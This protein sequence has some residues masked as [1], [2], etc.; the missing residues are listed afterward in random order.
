DAV[1]GSGASRQVT[2][3]PAC[4]K[5]GTA[6]ITVTVRDGVLQASDTFLLTVNPVN[7]PPTISD[8]V[9]QTINQDTSTGPLSF[10]VSD[11]ETP[12]ASLTVSGSSSNPT[13]GPHA[14]IVFGGS[15][16]NRPGTVSAAGGRLG[17]RPIA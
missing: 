3:L 7:D 8:I 10:T 14:N 1:C 12:A 5:S 6:T 2:V 15:G 11:V 13:L 9:N 17:A 4:N 16:R